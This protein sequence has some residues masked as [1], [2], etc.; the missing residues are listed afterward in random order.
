M[1]KLTI[2]K[3]G[4]NVINNEWLL[5]QVLADFAALEEVKILVHGGGKKASAL[6][7]Q[8]GLQ[9]KMVEGRRITDADALEV[10]TMV[11]AGLINKNIVAHLQAIGNNALGLTGADLN[12]IQAH[13]RR[14]SQIDYGFV[15]DIDAIQA[16]NIT[17]LLAAK[18]T[19]IF[20]AITHDKKGQLLNTNADSIAAS[21]AIGMSEQ[22]AVKLVLCFEKDGV[23]GNPNDD[24]TVLPSINYTQFQQYKAEGVIYEGMIP[25]LD[26]AFNALKNGVGE[27]YIA[28]PS[29]LAQNGIKGTQLCL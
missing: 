28:G 2:V 21:L 25:K 20:C 6:M 29:A 12:A 13:K 7:R 17:T 22:Y 26:G 16:T 4:G 24:T 8:M 10:V 19:P 9:P 5:T 18:F 3:I 27:V 14:N 1:K 11:Y 15:G 23:L